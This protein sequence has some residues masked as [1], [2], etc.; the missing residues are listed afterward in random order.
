M[1]IPSS[2]G[3]I[4]LQAPTLLALLPLVIVTEAI[5]RDGDFQQSGQQ[6]QWGPLLQEQ[7]LVC[8]CWVTLKTASIVRNSPPMPRE[9]KPTRLL[10]KDMASPLSPLP[11]ASSLNS[12]CTGGSILSA[13]TGTWVG[14]EHHSFLTPLVPDTDSWQ[15]WSIL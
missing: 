8:V 9:V 14:A 13:S 2:Q 1:C 15:L 3:L 11:R 5:E 10:G 6:R 4:L 7:P 12:H